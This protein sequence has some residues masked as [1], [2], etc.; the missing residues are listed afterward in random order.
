MARAVKQVSELG[1]LTKIGQGG[2]GVV[3]RAPNLKTK[4]TSSMVYKQYK[5]KA[6]NEI[7][8]SALAAMPELVEKSLTSDDGE[9]LISLAAWPCELVEEN[10]AQ[11]GFVMPEIP[12]EF[13]IPLTTLK[14]VSRNLAEFQHLLNAESILQARGIDI[15]DVQRYTL[16]REVASGLTF[17][18]SNGVCVGD[19][20]PKNLL[21]CLAPRAKIYFID[22]DA[23]RINGVSALPQVETPGWEIPSGEEP[24]TVYSDTY[25]L[26]LLAL[27]LLV[28]DQDV[29]TPQHIPAAAPKVLRGLITDTLERPTHKRPL[30][31]SWTYILGHAIEEAQHRKKTAAPP[32]PPP[33]AQTPPPP[34]PSPRRVPQQRNTAGRPTTSG[35]M[36]P[37]AKGSILAVVGG[38]AILVVALLAI[39]SQ[40][41][42]DSGSQAPSSSYAYPTTR[43]G[44]YGGSTSFALSTPSTRPSLPLGT[45]PDVLHG[46]DGSGD[47]ACSGGHSLYANGR[48]YLVAPATPRGPHYTS[49]GFAIAVGQT[50]LATVSDWQYPTQI[51]VQSPKAN[52]TNAQCDGTKFVMQCRMDGPYAAMWIECRGGNDAVVYIFGG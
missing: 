44:D 43:Y 34:Q 31:E 25:K 39:G 6:R 38:L 28:G 10:G 11:T 45:P 36:S 14:G 4:F 35:Q 23:M 41:G 12:D 48:S 2:Q 9:R 13:F 29:R 16:L 17:L 46:A 27:R 20:S 3:Y 21:F 37:A 22:C 1:E 5:A 26:G 7:D 52:C 19:I 33:V 49:C 40:R 18:H 50:Y 15:D 51:S 47:Y 32:K 30:P 42:P 8:F 24:A